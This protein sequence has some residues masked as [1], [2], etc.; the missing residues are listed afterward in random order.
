[1]K[2]LLL[3]TSLAMLGAA[4]CGDD[5][6]STG[7]TAAAEFDIIQAGVDAYTGSD[8]P[9][10]INA[11]EL[12]ENMNDGDASNDPVIVSVRS[13]AHYAL[14]HIQGAVNIPWRE[15]AEPN[16]LAKL[17][18][19]DDIV[20]YCYTGHTGGVAT[21]ALNAM[22]YHATNLKF[23]M[24]GWTKNEAVRVAKP[25]SEA[26]DANDYP[27]ELTSNPVGT[28]ALAAPDNTTSEDGTEVIRAA[29]ESYL[30]D[31]SK[32]PTIAAKD[33]FENLNDGDT[34]NDPVILSVRSAQ[35]YAT[36]HIPG[37]INIPW[38]EVAR[39]ENLIGLPTDQQIVV[40]CYT[41]HTGAVATAALNMLGYDAVNMKFG[42]GAWTTDATVRVAAPFSEDTAPDLP[43]VQ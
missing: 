9:P 3:L 37:A 32:P 26:T 1:M 24:V 19:N 16:Q 38:R 34:S 27:V 15:I 41:G 20:V 2:S 10:T 12:W 40:Y 17:S 42:M 5:D 23:G 28:F 33:V 22:G 4:G 36:G 25:F 39:V 6:K 11:Q 7:P 21:A 35:H 43:T 18:K 30:A 31:T 29:A 14:G 13:E 8:M